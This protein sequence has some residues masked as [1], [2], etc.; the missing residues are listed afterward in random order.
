MNET[1]S[2]FLTLREVFHGRLSEA[3]LSRCTI[4]YCTNY[5]NI[6]YL[7]IQLRPEDNL[8]IICNSIISD[9]NLEKEIF[10]KNKLTKLIG[11]IEILTF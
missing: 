11:K 1:F 8:K 3:V 10:S 6:N 4:I 9:E 5:D 7:T 2:I